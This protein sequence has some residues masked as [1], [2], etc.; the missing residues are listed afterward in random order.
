MKVDELSINF[1][2]NNK[3]I[4]VKLYQRYLEER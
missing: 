3:D 4:K 1:E 2:K